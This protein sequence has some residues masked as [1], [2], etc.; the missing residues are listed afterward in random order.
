MFDIECIKKA[1]NSQKEELTYYINKDKEEKENLKIDMKNTP[2]KDRFAIKMYWENRIE[3]NKKYLIA[4]KEIVKNL[5]KAYK[6]MINFDELFC[7]NI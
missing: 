7:G 6:S 5:E 3:R 4:K 1:L 2:E